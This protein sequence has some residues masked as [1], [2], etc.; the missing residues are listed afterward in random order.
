MANNTQYRVRCETC[1]EVFVWADAE[2]TEC[3]NDGGHSLVSGCI[4]VI[5][6]K[7]FGHTCAASAP[8]V[9][10]DETKGYRTGWQWHDSAGDDTYLCVDA[11]AGAA[12][13]MEFTAGSRIVEEAIDHT[14]PGDGTDDRVIDL[15]ADYDM[16]RI[17]NEESRYY[18]VDHAVEATAF[19]TFYGILYQDGVAEKTK[20]K[21]LAVANGTWQGKVAGGGGTTIKLG[22]NGTTATGLNVSGETYRLFAL[23][24]SAMT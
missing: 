2:P 1:G 22:S 11:A 5:S 10:D 21:Q 12:V 24:F 14:W 7:G 3:P 19:K 4:A 13:W 15:G 18:D 17:W 20:H 23:R 16:I 9:N 8:T 6:W